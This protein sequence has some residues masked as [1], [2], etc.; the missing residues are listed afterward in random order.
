[1]WWDIFR[2]KPNFKKYGWTHCVVHH[3]LT[4]DNNTLPDIQ[5]IRKYHIEHKG[6]NFLGYHA[7]LEKING[8]YEILMGRPLNMNGAHTK[9]KNSTALGICVVGNF[10][11]KE[12]SK[13]ALQ[14]LAILVKSWMDMFDIPLKNV[15][16]HRDF[17]SYKSCPG[18]MFSIVE[19][20]KLI[21]E[22]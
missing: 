14:L 2:R 6:W 12:P 18:K 3:S 4:D 10:D 9:G 7:V 22:I 16:G 13:E 1:M 21:V 8:K 15:K 17:A 11:K 5:A 20:K 19:L